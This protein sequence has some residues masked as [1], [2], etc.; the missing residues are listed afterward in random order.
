MDERF[1]RLLGDVDGD[2][3][4]TDLDVGA[5]DHVLMLGVY[6]PEADVNGDGLINVTDRVRITRAMGRKLADG[7]PF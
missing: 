6:D 1:H 4:V 7:L 5:V 3:R 2:G